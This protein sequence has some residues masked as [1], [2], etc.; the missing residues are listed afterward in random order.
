MPVPHSTARRRAPACVFGGLFVSFSHACLAQASAAATPPNTLAP[1][2]VTGNPLRSTASA[3]PVSVLSGDELVLRR[4][5]SLGETLNGQPG[6]SSTYFGPNANRP[7]IRGLDGDRVRLLGNGGASIDVSSVSFDHA[8][9]IDPLIVERIEV[10]R[11]PGALMYGGSAVGGVVNA[12]DN[13]IPRAGILG[14]AG[15]AELRI[16]GAERERGGALLMETGNGR[17]ALHADAFGR[18]SSD[19]RVPRFSPI[20][21][22]GVLAP[23]TTV[24]NSAARASGGALGGSLTFGSGYIGLSA[25]TYGSRYGIVAEPDV[26]IRMQRDHVALAG[27]WREL[28]GPLRT[29]RAQFNRTRYEHREI[30]GSGAVGTTFASTGDELRVEAEHAPIGTWRGVVGLQLEDVDFSALG[31]EAFVPGT[32]TRR[33]GLFVLEETRWPLGTLSAGLRVERA[34]IH[35]A[36]DADP[37][38]AQFGPAQQ[39]RFLLRSTSLANTWAFTPAWSL[40]TTLSATERAPTAPELYANGV[41]AATGA[42]E[43]GD[44]ALPAERGHNLDVALQWRSGED[45]LR[46]GVFA[47]RFSRFISL[48]ASGATIELPDED[49]G[50]ESLPEYLFRPVRA[51]LHGLEID[52]RLRLIERPWMLDL[53][54]T[55]DITRATNADNGEPLPRIAPL[56]LRVSFDAAGGPWGLRVEID[57]AA[58]QTRVPATDVPTAGH[59][60]LNLALT[61]RFTLGPADALWFVRLDNAGDTLAASAST[62]RTVRELAPLPGRSLRTGLRVSF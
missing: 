43:R 36:G 62:I 30:E 54:G 53:T 45:R 3:A 29:L 19:L 38:A 48:E 18:E 60:L 33:Q 6:V 52:G 40:A 26:T 28:S 31:E 61:R 22:G 11:G 12:I 7:V 57:H 21:E 46:A 9:P 50:I 56:R 42:Y 10:L 13:R 44:P 35:S 41:H 47:A 27:E 16:G 37:A 34:R 59:T 1:V 14:P 39:R 5:A 32:T 55:L 23:A 49:G 4:G 51:R 8:V 20:E 17:F 25:D 15:A 24:R 58:R 2:V